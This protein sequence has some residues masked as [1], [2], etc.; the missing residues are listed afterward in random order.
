MFCGDCGTPNPD[1]NAFCKNCGSAL[2]RPQQ[3]PAPAPHPAAAPAPAA[4]DAPQPVYY[5]QPANFP[6][7]PPYVQQQAPQ[8]AATITKQPWSMGKKIAVISIICG[9]AA[10]IIIP[11]I[12]GF[13][14]IILGAISLTKKYVPGA[15]GIVISF[16]AILVN[17]LYVFIA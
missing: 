10:F 14:G 3:A 7:Q 17:Y 2:R 16:V 15:A 12:L 9:I 11:Y 6:Q 8:Q 13:I 1:T 4:P 5:Q